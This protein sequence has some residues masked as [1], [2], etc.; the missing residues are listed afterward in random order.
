MVV[1]HINLGQLNQKQP[2]YVLIVTYFEG[3]NQ[4]PGS[5]RSIYAGTHI[6][7]YNYKTIDEKINEFGDWCGPEF[8]IGRT[9]YEKYIKMLVISKLTR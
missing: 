2:G 8:I 7:T 9:M 6:Y 5:I 1:Y 3:F 4:E